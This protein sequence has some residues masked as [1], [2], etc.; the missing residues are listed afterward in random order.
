MKKLL[1]FLTVCSMGFGSSI[2]LLPKQGAYEV[3]RSSALFRKFN[4]GTHIADSQQWGSRA[5]WDFA[6]SGGAANSDITLKDYDGQSVMV[7]AGA[8]LVD[9]YLD[10]VTAPTSSTS[11]GSLAWSSS[12]VGDLKAATFVN[13]YTTGSLIHCTKP[14]GSFTSGTMIR[15]TSEGTLKVRVG[16]EAITA[17]KINV[18]LQYILSGAL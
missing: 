4:V 12:D 8:V 3:N 15:F 13:S 1:L 18:Y 14:S 5:Q 6:A 2:T 11:S 10:V 17:G 7:P 9:C 16:S